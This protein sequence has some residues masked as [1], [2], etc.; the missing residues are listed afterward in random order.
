MTATTMA[1]RREVRAIGLIGFAH[2]LS[3][4]YM[5][6]L[7]PLFLL[8]QAEFDVSFVE[9]GL[10]ITLYNV[11]TA[12]L[13]TPMG[14]L[15]DRLGARRIL[16]AGLFVNALAVALAGLASSYVE[17]LL[18][19]LVAG[20][21]NSVFHPADYVILTASVDERRQGK[22]YS[23][24]S[25]GGSLGFAAAPSVMITLADWTD[26]RT[27]LIIVGLAGVVLSFVFV[28]S[29]D[30][31]REDART[32]SRP[33]QRVSLRQ[34]ITVPV[35]LFFL[36]YV[37]MAAS[38]IG[39]TGFA[40][41]FLPEMYG[42]SIQTASHMLS[43]M[44]LA[45]A[46]GTLFGGP[47]ADRVR[48][49]DLVLTACFGAGALLTIAVGTAA[50]P[51]FLV[52]VAFAGNGFLRGIVNPSRDIMVRQISPPGALG[53]VFAFVTTGFS[54]GQGLA[55]ILYGLLLD[56][57]MVPAVLYVSAA[58]TLLMIGLSVSSRERRAR[59]PA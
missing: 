13:Q 57:G 1:I 31:L 33:D 34:T 42:M 32:K 51:A 48:N 10:I 55:P 23:I 41:V 14:V 21:G 50:L 19:F 40:A 22:A 17:L 30:T 2:F 43:I 25:F 46:V 27:A 35:M 24:H 53:T 15:V 39:L 5:L 7:V 16:I 4:F 20:A 36:F 29:G 58:F 47:V 56:R 49:H 6:S 26:W 9:L 8:V 38:S 37:C 45:G 52:L 28:F 44:L 18:L 12:V 11:A 59:R 3:H 54:I